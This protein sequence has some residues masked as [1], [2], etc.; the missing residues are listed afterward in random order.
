MA[1]PPSPH[2]DSRAISIGRALARARGQ[3]HRRSAAWVSLGSGVFAFGVGL[4]IWS[5]ID[6]SFRN[7][8]EIVSRI[9]LA[10]YPKQQDTAAYLMAIFSV[11]AGVAAGWYA[12]CFFA[13]A[14]IRASNACDA[15]LDASLARGIWPFVALLL[16][17]VPIAGARWGVAELVAWRDIFQ[18]LHWHRQGRA[19]FRH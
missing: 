19:R 4:C 16:A 5:A 1:E 18:Y 15:E 8:F 2:L 7:P 10:R 9:T 17:I 3:Q 14:R 6:F 11:T 12:W 13:S